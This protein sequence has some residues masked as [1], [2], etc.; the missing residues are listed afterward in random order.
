VLAP[1]CSSE[2]TGA[3]P[4]NEHLKRKPMSKVRQQVAT[5]SPRADAVAEMDPAA[6]SDRPQPTRVPVEGDGR[7]LR[8][9]LR[10]DVK[11]HTQAQLGEGVECRLPLNPESVAAEHGP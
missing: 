11:I 2:V 6:A 10:S 5:N 8:E 9:R 4:T 7:K 3:L 1:V